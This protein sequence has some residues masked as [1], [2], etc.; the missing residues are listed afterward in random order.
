MNNWDLKKMS[1][2]VDN[3]KWMCANKETKTKRRKQV[4]LTV[5]KTDWQLQK[6]TN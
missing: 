1:C 3:K 2:A 4:L 6:W 5:T